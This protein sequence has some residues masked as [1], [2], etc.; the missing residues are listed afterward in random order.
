MSQDSS[1]IEGT[2]Y[3]LDDWG[4]GSVFGPVLKGTVQPIK[5]ALWI[6]FLWLKSARAWSWPLTFIVCWCLEWV[7][8]FFTVTMWCLRTR[9]ALLYSFICHIFWI[10]WTHGLPTHV[11][12][13]KLKKY[14]RIHLVVYVSYGNIQCGG[15]KSRLVEGS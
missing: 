14:Y 13:L 8:R 6:L 15:V 10:F 1:A 7:S 9:S 4:K 5:W 3:G 2:S 11:R 12:L